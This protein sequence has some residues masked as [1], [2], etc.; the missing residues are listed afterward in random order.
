M[1]VIHIA[2]DNP[3]SPKAYSM[4]Y[5][6]REIHNNL[7]QPNFL[8]SKASPL[9]AVDA[10]NYAALAAQN[11]LSTHLSSFCSS[12]NLFCF[13]DLAANLENH[14]TDSNFVS[15]LDRNFTNYGT[16]RNS[17]VDSFKN[18][19][20]GDNLPIDSFSRYSRDSVGHKDEFSNYASDGNI[21][22]QSFHSYAGG[23]NAGAG[24]FNNYNQ[25]V[26]DPN[27]RFTS[28]AQEA[29]GRDHSFTSYTGQTNAGSETFTTYGKNGNGTPNDF[30]SY[31]EGSNA[32]D[33]NF[34]NYGENGKQ[35]NDTFTSYGSNGNVPE[36]NFNNY[37]AQA[38]SGSET[39][40]SY[41]EQANVGDDSFQS[42]GKKSDSEKIDFANY[43]QSFHN[44]TDKFSSYGAGAKG[45]VVGFKIYALN[46]TFKDYKD[47][48]A[49]TFTQYTE[50]EMV[51]GSLVNK[52]VEPGKFF[53]ESM[54]KEGKVMPMPDIKDKM[55]KR[56]F[57][58]RAIVS[59]LP[60]ST[61]KLAEIKQTFL[62]RD[63]STMERIIKD[64]L[65]ECERAPSAGETKHCV[66]SIEDM[67]DFASSVLGGN[68]VVRTTENLNG[69][70]Q[71]IMIGS[72]KGI[73]GGRV[74]KSVSCHQSLYPYLLYYCH[75]VP[76]VRVYGAD[77]LD[78]DTKA[79]INHGVAICHLDT[80]AWSPTH[81][82]FLALGSSPGQIEV[83]HW[84]FENDMA[85]TMAD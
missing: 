43:G 55:P 29:N 73:N 14:D 60:F 75:S 22:D 72:V 11:S 62:A 8:L 74:T 85:W 25:G 35:D 33:S 4:R 63:N 67:I 18:Y 83:C 68:V 71:E 21:V 49:T 13:P 30:S 7:P 81:G 28:Y 50:A 70:K 31:G 26:N 46:T 84:I 45:E 1:Q 23:A 3:F 57:L 17:G 58:P 20:E 64:A 48:N 53:R 2:G 44:G 66:A 54:L 56:S 82:A 5:W 15:Y 41:R 59:K 79:K 36:N 69:S 16:D 78:P 52:W 77:I 10:A 12:A 27:L 39:F 80:K 32:I 24:E 34:N 47:Q 38:S 65:S 42:Y 76:R 6:N 40:T 37:G 9:S 19:S 51:S 61:S